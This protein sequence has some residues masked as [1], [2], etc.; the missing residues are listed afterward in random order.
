[1]RK[2]LEALALVVI[3]GPATPAWAQ[4]RPSA[5]SPI[6]PNSIYYTRVDTGEVVTLSSLGQPQSS[7]LSRFLH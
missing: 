4:Q 1:V 3:L 5:F 7:G 6:N 2:A